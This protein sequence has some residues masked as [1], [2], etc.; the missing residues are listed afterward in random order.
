ME[1]KCER[2][3]RGTRANWE[4]LPAKNKRKNETG[5][6]IPNL[7]DRPINRSESRLGTEGQACPQGKGNW[8]QG[9]QPE[10]EMVDPHRARVETREEVG[11]RPKNLMPGE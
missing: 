1:P 9:D 7:K 5:A 11:E 6:T 8:D 2:A 3:T 4:G 10:P